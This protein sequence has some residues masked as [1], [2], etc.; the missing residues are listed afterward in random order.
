[1]A[2]YSHWEYHENNE[3]PIASHRKRYILCCRQWRRYGI[4][5]ITFNKFELYKNNIRAQIRK[6]R[7]LERITIQ[8]I[9]NI[10]YLI[11]IDKLLK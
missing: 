1:M 9:K 5:M 10:L 11:S 4:I 7:L 2:D 6:N 8:I 3:M